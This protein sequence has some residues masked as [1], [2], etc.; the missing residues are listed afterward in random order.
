MYEFYYKYIKRNYDAKLLFTDTDSL[1]YEIKAEEAYED[2]YKNKSFFDLNDY[3]Q[4]SKFV[5]PVNKK[6]L[7]KMKDEFLLEMISQFIGLKSK[8]YSLIKEYSEEVIKA[9]RMDKKII[10]NIRQKEY[11]DDFFNSKTQDEKN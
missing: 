3:P 1:V 10:K 8:M 5:D 6:V 4:H 2:F 7:R 11:T 9:K